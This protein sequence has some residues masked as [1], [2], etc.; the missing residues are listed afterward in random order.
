M[1]EVSESNDVKIHVFN[2]AIDQALEQIDKWMDTVARNYGAGISTG[3]FKDLEVAKS[4]FLSK[5]NLLGAVRKS[6]MDQKIPQQKA[7]DSLREL[8]VWS[9]ESL[10]KAGLNE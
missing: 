6:I 7:A 1:G 8:M 9:K 10:K 5:R 3:A 4:N 2:R